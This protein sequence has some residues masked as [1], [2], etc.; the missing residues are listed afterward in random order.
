M[1]SS[2]LDQVFVYVRDY[3]T[4]RGYAPTY[5]EIMVSCHFA[6]TASVKYYLERLARSGRIHFTPGVSRGIALKEAERETS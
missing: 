3:I 2:R 5:R 6:S 4:K 1:A